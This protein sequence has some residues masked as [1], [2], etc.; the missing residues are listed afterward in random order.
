MDFLQV[1]ATLG[2]GILLGLGISF[3]YNKTRK[4]VG[5]LLITKNEE[6]QYSYLLRLAEEPEDLHRRKVIVFK[7]KKEQ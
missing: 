2:I 6:D 3:S 4:S 7:V 5:D 1:V